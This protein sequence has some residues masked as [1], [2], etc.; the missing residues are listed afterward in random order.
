[1]AVY[2]A[3]DIT[4]RATTWA[5]PL[6]PHLFHQLVLGIRAARRVSLQQLG[7]DEAEPGSWAAKLARAGDDFDESMYRRGWSGA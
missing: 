1:M 2:E 3:I 7:R 4:H 5:H 6:N